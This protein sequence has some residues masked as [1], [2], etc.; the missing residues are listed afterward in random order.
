MRT[1]SLLPSATEIVCALGAQGELVGVS[2]ECDFPEGLAG[3]PVLTR[4]RSR[5][6]RSPRSIPTW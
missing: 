6:P 4:P 3:L 1:A 2:H 5:R